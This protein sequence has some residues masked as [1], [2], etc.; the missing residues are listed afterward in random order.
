MLIIEM[1]TRIISVVKVAYWRF[2]QIYTR[3][4]SICNSI[5]L[6]LFQRKGNNVTFALTVKY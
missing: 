4:S 3:L 2:I 6:T 1:R 5:S